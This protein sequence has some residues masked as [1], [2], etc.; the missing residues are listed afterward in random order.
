RARAETYRQASIRAENRLPAGA[1]DSVIAYLTAAVAFSPD[2]TALRQ[3]LA[4]V[5]YEEYLARRATDPWTAEREYLRPALRDYL[6]AREANPLLHQPHARL[7]GNRS[8]L[9]NAESTIRYL[10]RAT[11][12]R[13]VEPGLWY[14]LGLAHLTADTPER[15][16]ACWRKS[17]LCSPAHLELM[18]PQTLARGGASALVEGVLPADAKLVLEAAKSPALAGQ[19]VARRVVLERALELA[20][21][22]PGRADALYRRAWLLREL[23]RTAEAI[24]AYDLAVSRDP[25]QAEWRVELAELY[26]AAG[27]PKSA[28]EHVRRALRDRPDFRPARD[29]DAKLLGVS[30]P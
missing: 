6:A 7:A 10:E 12:V 20:G 15:A 5:R 2:D 4:D 18:I 25:D 14:L 16:W 23:G 17:L 8:Q 22:A 13:P 19:P 26:L 1:R 24:R 30:A 9:T 29:L 11:R 28:A 21:D 27:D 3:R